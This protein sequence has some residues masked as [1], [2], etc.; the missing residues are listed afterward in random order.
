MPQAESAAPPAAPSSVAST[1]SLSPSPS[2][3][4]PPSSDPVPSAS[5]EVP[6]VWTPVGVPSDVA[7][8]LI[9]DCVNRASELYVI[10]GFDVDEAQ[11]IERPVVPRLVVYMPVLDGGSSR[12]MK[13]SVSDWPASTTIE[14]VTLGAVLVGNDLE[15]LAETPEEFFTR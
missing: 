12:A 8:A 9:F 10:V 5:P 4:A 14:E 7:S 13:C 3:S 11:V 6:E 15:K 2:P 1:P